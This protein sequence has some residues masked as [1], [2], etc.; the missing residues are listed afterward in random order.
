MKCCYGAPTAPASRNGPTELFKM[1]LCMYH[2]CNEDQLTEM[3]TICGGHSNDFE[4][5]MT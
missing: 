2:Q 1:L 3:K 4:A 5:S